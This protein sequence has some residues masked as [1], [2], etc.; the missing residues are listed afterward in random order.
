MKNLLLLF[1]VLCAT[2][3]FAQKQ[4]TSS[5][6]ALLYLYVDEIPKFPG[7][8]SA[9]GKFINT[10]VK[11]P[12]LFDGAGSVVISFIVKKDGT[13]AGSK[14][15]QSLSDECNNEAIRIV[16]LFPNWTPGKLNGNP[17]DVILYLPIRFAIGTSAVDYNVN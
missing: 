12:E 5:E 3:C 14:I 10:N 13:I 7:G 9:L 17:V 1:C 15:V 11:W 8:N 6:R 2:S 4:M 16:S